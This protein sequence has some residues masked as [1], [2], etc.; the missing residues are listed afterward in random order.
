MSKHARNRVG[1]MRQTSTREIVVNETLR[2]ESGEEPLDDTLLQVE[3]DDLICNDSGVLEDN[4]ANRRCASPFP[5]LL[6]AFARRR[7]SC[8]SFPPMSGRRLRVGPWPEKCIPRRFESSGPGF[9][10]S[11]PRIWSAQEMADR[12]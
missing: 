7:A 5:E 1:S 9:R 8:P 2:G 6:V 4:G 12:K 11:A 10:G 3:L